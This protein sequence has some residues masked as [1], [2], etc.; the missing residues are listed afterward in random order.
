MLCQLEEA[1]TDLL[2]ANGLSRQKDIEHAEKTML[3]KMEVE[4]LRTI[5][6]EQG[7]QLE[8]VRKE[9]LALE[10]VY[11][12]KLEELKLTLEKQ[13]QDELQSTKQ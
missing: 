4:R 6:R 5:M 1:R 10:G 12:I 7:E 2:K 11:L 13:F 3:L 9:W 8:Q